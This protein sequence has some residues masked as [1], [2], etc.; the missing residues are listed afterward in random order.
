MPDIKGKIV[1]ADEVAKFYKDYPDFW[2]LLEVLKTSAEGK[3]ELMRVPAY[4]KSKDVLR[5]YLLDELDNTNSKYIFVYAD[6][7]GKCEI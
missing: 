5:E 4:D 3:A 7:D 1:T 6:P 2:F